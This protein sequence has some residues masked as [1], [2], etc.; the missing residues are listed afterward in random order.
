MSKDLS[1]DPRI[2]AIVSD[3]IKNWMLSRSEPV[4]E[5]QDLIRYRRYTTRKW[6]FLLVCLAAVIVSAG[7]GLTVGQYDIGFLEAYGIIWDHMTGNV[8]DVLKDYIIVKLRLPSIVVGIIA[9]IGL[10]ICGAAMQSVLKNPLADPY[11]TGVS[12]G[13][14]FGATLAIVMGA[15]ITSSQYSIVLNAFIFSLIPTIA[16]IGF[17][18]LKQ[19]SPTTM[20]MAGIAIM[21]IFNAFSTL[22][23]LW[24]DPNDIAAVFNWQIGTLSGVGWSNVPLLLIVTLA[25]FVVIQVLSRKLNVLAT[26]ED[27]A[28]SLGIDVDRLRMISLI[29]VALVAATIVSFTGLIGFVGLIAPHVARIIIG[30]DNRY[31]V[32]ASALF[33]AALLVTA[34]TIGKVIVAPSVIQVGVIT[35]FIGGPMFLWLILRKKS[36]LWG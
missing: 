30:A 23:K 18:R 27:S 3:S 31:L 33:G 29:T 14:G 25:G 36:E 13:A 32:P 28:K 34:H 1:E 22:M 26:G 16:I 6:L 21:Y 12:S 5:T 11:T 24:A 35:A 4:E 10:A 19:S 20:I 8:Q 2:G 15:S 7:I 9:G 17:S